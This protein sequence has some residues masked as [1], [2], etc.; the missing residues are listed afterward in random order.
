MLPV[1]GVPL[2]L[3]SYGGSSLLASLAGVGVLVSCA[4]HEPDAVAWRTNHRLTRKP[5]R[6]LSAVLPGQRT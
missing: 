5:R 4:L 3:V 2:P 6:R 1:L